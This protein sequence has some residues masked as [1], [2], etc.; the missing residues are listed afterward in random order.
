MLSQV[1]KRIQENCTIITKTDEAV[2]CLAQK[3]Y[4]EY[5]DRSKTP[6]EDDIDFF[7][8]KRRCRNQKDQQEDYLYAV[9][10]TTLVSN[11][12]LGIAE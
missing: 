4:A 1:D 9:F 5:G 7:G 11:D 12:F 6:H 2:W 3:I 10:L 8:E